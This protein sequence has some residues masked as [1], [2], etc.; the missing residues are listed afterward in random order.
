ML[1]M[2]KVID[3]VD[4]T[5]LLNDLQII[6]DIGEITLVRLQG[7]DLSADEFTFYLSKALYIEHND[8][9][10]KKSTIVNTLESLSI[11]KQNLREDEHFHMFQ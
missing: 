9:I 1:D 7:D 4:R 8:D 2:S 10:W 3:I 11:L 6:L 5:T